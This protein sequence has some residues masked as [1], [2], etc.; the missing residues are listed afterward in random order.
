MS[1][2]ISPVP[3]LRLVTGPKGAGKTRWCK[4]AI[5]GVRA[6]GGPVA[7]VLSAGVFA[8]G[9]KVAIVVRDLGRGEERLLARRRFDNGNGAPRAW[10]FD[11]AAL[12]WANSRL[13][14]VGPCHTLVVDEL[15]PL[16]LQQERGWTAVWQ[17]LRRRSF[18][19]AILTVRPS[20]LALLHARI[21]PLGAFEIQPVLLSGEPDWKHA[22]QA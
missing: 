20:L 3:R 14:A 1:C 5:A 18:T 16:E 8:A 22:S 10:E 6:A 2:V 4:Q 17:V 12:E 21:Q 13:A 15:G 7:G 11:E 9:Q 19:Q